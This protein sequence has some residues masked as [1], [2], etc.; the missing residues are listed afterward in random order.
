MKPAL[1][2]CSLAVLILALA[3]NP[4]PPAGGGESS[5]ATESATT[6]TWM[7][8]FDTADAGFLSSVWGSAPDDV[9]IV[10]GQPDRAQAYH[11][12]GTGWSAMNLPQV[13]LLIWVFG[14]SPDA[15]F[16]V[17]EQGTALF[18]DGTDWQITETGTSSDL[19]GVWG[20]AVDDVWA[21]GGDVAAGPMVILHYDGRA[22]QPVTLPELDRESTALLKVWGSSARHVFAVGQSGV[23]LGYDG[24]EWSQ[25]PSGT[26]QDLITLWGTGPDHIVAVGGRSNGVLAVFDGAGW[27]SQ[28]VAPLPGLN[29][30]FL[31]N[32]TQAV[33]VGLIGTAAS[34]NLS[35]FEVTP[36]VTPTVQ[37]LHAVWGDGS[38]TFY[39]VGGSSTA[40]PYTGV[41]LVAT[42]E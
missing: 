39:A 25:V 7:P 35:T 42:A 40:Q 9:Y 29:G 28:S 18:F 8:A 30:V 10:G 27:S 22:W 34:I 38:G 24:L 32:P 26:G 11:F 19:F 36:Q 14:V 3:C 21:V 2:R 4:G 12:D 41:A 23:I 37:T 5:L 20:S 6:L 1:I 15:V 33:V 13:P 17:G 31:D 16:A